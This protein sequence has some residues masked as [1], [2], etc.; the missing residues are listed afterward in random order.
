MK[1]L[2]NEGR[3]IQ[4][5]F[6]LK[7]IKES[8]NEEKINVRGKMVEEPEKF[9]IKCYKNPN[10][11]VGQSSYGNLKKGD[12]LVETASLSYKGTN[13]INKATVFNN[14][15]KMRPGRVDK[16]PRIFRW[17]SVKKTEKFE[18]GDF[19]E[20]LPVEVKTVRTVKLV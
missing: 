13:D 16:S 5:T 7:S 17:N 14:K 1:D 20:P 4:E 8:L 6:S 18:M 3:K 12:Y 19:F 11:V 15:N 9:V 10:D 2:I